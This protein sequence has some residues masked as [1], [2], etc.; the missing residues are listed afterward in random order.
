MANQTC[1]VP[2]S[3]GQHPDG[4]DFQASCAPPPW[5]A[6]MSHNGAHAG[7]SHTQGRRIAKAPRPPSFR[8]CHSRAPRGV[9]A[10]DW[11]VQ[12]PRHRPSGDFA[13]TRRGVSATGGHG[14]NT[15]SPIRVSK[16][17]CY[18]KFRRFVRGTCEGNTSRCARRLHIMAKAEKNGHM[19]AEVPTNPTTGGPT[20]V[21]NGIVSSV[22]CQ[23][24]TFV[25]AAGPS[26][27]AVKCPGR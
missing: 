6:A 25:C 24:A 26:H 11:V 1:G 13:R 12:S 16:L 9:C 14:H 8:T 27:F 10:I 4:S 20:R 18:A 23:H 3:R 22:P 5:P 2:L 19:S 21:Y 17:K 7:A 15:Q